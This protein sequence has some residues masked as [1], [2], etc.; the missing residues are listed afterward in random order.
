V[1]PV[2]VYETLPL[3]ITV[4]VPVAL[5][6]ALLVGYAIYFL[7]KHQQKSVSGSG[8]GGG[9]CQR[10]DSGNTSRPTPPSCPPPAVPRGVYKEVCAPVGTLPISR[11]QSRVFVLRSKLSEHRPSDAAART[12]RCTS[13]TSS[14]SASTP[15]STSCC[16]ALAA[17]ARSSTAPTTDSSRRRATAGCLTTTTTTVVRTATATVAPT[18]RRVWAEATATCS[19]RPP[20]APTTSWPRRRRP[21]AATTRAW[22]PASASCSPCSTRAAERASA[23]DCFLATKSAL[24]WIEWFPRFR[25]K[26]QQGKGQAFRRRLQSS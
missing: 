17:S 13:T 8:S 23:R 10:T 4:G 7:Q 5:L 18:R 11:N 9:L 20:V 26:K 22:A 24:N 19:C 15:S 12:D 21:T 14:A 6:L 1:E 3:H 2:V 16:W 25:I